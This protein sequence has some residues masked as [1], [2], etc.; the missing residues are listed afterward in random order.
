MQKVGTMPPTI[1]YD[2]FRLAPSVGEIANA[3]L[4]ILRGQH[5][6]HE[7]VALHRSP[8]QLKVV[9]HRTT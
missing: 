4:Q 6:L 5:N 7:Y 8:S 1:L 9:T 3:A 2:M